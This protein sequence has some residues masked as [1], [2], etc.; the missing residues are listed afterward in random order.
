MFGPE[1]VVLRIVGDA[2]P[3]EFR[4]G[5]FVYVDPDEPAAP[6]R[7]V[8]L[9]ADDAETATVGR[10]VDD[11]RTWRV[12]TA[13]GARPDIVFGTD[14]ETAILGVVVFTGARV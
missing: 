12:R 4:A 9:A 8:A 10:V 13:D 11:G 14:A 7:F 1:T 5:D 6:G 2:V 3:P